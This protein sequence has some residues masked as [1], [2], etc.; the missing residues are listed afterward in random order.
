MLFW[1]TEVETSKQS[2]KTNYRI[3]AT[4]HLCQAILVNSQRQIS[5]VMLGL[6][7]RLLS[8]VSKSHRQKGRSRVDTCL[9]KLVLGDYLC[10]VPD[11][12][13]MEKE[14]LETFIYA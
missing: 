12:L 5:E 9:Q 8:V 3:A 11:E 14:M 13:N 6:H 7:Y 4:L 1:K 10:A 2:R